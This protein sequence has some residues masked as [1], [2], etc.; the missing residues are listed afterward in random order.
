MQIPSNI[1]NIINI[2]SSINLYYAFFIIFI[3]FYFIFALCTWSFI[4]PLKFIGSVNITVGIMFMSIKLI[5]PIINSLN[6]NNMIKEVLPVI[7][8]P[9][10]IS[11]IV[12]L[13][14][15]I[16]LLIIYELINMISKKKNK[17]VVHETKEE[18]VEEI[19]KVDK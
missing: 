17:E 3:F 14:F 12:S 5:S 15:G 4:K 8:D 10:F 11:G 18:V 9:L 2:V 7:I 6:I 1:L 16:L 13:S 19:K